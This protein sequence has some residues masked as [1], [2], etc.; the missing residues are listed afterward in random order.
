MFVMDTFGATRNIYFQQQLEETALKTPEF[1]ATTTTPASRRVK[2]TIV[3]TGVKLPCPKGFV[4]VDDLSQCIPQQR[5]VLP[6]NFRRNTTGRRPIIGGTSATVS[7]AP[8]EAL[9][10]TTE[11]MTFSTSKNSATATDGQGFTL[12]KSMSTTETNSIYDTND[13]GYEFQFTQKLPSTG[14]V[15]SDGSSTFKTDTTDGDLENAHSTRLQYG[16]ESSDPF[17]F[18]TSAI[19]LSTEVALPAVDVAYVHL[20]QLRLL[21]TSRHR[22]CKHLYDERL[23][24]N[25]GDDDYD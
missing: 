25:S 9:F 8:P 14:T 16:S 10:S 22:N 2:R 6:N 18:T 1:H 7:I 23:F 5:F 4:R 11:S 15:P 3:P 17:K 20:R 13:T 21:A 19:E 12:E 24:R